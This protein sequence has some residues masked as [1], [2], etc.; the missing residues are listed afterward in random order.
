[1]CP[2]DMERRDRERRRRIRRRRGRG[3]LTGSS[4][5]G[6]W[7]SQ[8]G[9]SSLTQSGIKCILMCERIALVLRQ[10]DLGAKPPI[11]RWSSPSTNPAAVESNPNTHSEN[12]RIL[13]P[14]ALVNLGLGVMS[15]S[16]QEYR[17]CPNGTTTRGDVKSCHAL[18]QGP[19]TA[20]RVVPV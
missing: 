13:Y 7:S 2:G 18:N 4:K 17:K 12:F 10:T 3:W 5:V 11:S 9:R 8:Q 14:K 1:M 15:S 16:R 19:R 20:K 6:Q